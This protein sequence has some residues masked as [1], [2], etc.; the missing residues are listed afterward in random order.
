MDQCIL[1]NLLA[2]IAVLYVRRANRRRRQR[3]RGR[4]TYWVKLRHPIFGQYG[5]HLQELNREDVR[6]LKNILH[7]P[8]EL[9]QERVGPLIHKKDTFWRKALDPG[10]KLA[11]TLRYLAIGD[12][13]KTLQ[14]GFRVAVNTICNII[15]DT[16]QAIIEEECMHAVV[17]HHIL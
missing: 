16:C 13:Y 1:V 10:L 12:S 4:K 11:I 7:I 17:T 2:A 8:L 3:E 6:A 15:P 9:F 5:R 14:Y